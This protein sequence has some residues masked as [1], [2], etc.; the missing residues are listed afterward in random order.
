MDDEKPPARRLV[1]KHRDVEPVDTISRPGDGT[2]I[3]VQLIHLE[4]KLAE[5]RPIGRRALDPADPPG[6]GHPEGVLS[7]FRPKEITPIDPPSPAGDESAISVSDMLQENRVAALDS[8]PELIAMPP[9]RSSR[10]H[11]DFAVLI[12]CAL[13]SVGV[14]T[15]IFRHDM[16]VVALALFGIVFLTVILAWVMYGV[17]DRY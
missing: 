16:Q 10:R 4:N 7:P 8:G 15:A 3:S 11:R 6:T 17:M 5:G 12:S 1:L 13:I 14:V 9:R 2:A